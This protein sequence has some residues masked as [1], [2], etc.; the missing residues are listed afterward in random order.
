MELYEHFDVF[1]NCSR[2]PAFH[3]RVAKEKGT[4]LRGLFFGHHVVWP[5]DE[6]TV[7]LL[8]GCRYHEKFSDSRRPLFALADAIGSMFLL[9]HRVYSPFST[10]VDPTQ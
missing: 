10:T 1:R 7:L 5:I 3:H 4:Q 9:V 2:I 6:L 8:E